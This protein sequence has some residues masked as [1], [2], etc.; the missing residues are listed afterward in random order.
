MRGAGDAVLFTRNFEPA[1]SATKIEPGGEDS[2][3]PPFFAELVPVQAGAQS[4]VI[5]GP[6]DAQLGE[7]VLAGAAPSVDHRAT[8]EFL[9]NADAELVYNGRRLAEPH[10]LG[11]V[12]GGRRSDV[13][14][15][16]HVPC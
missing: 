16:G 4:I 2:E 3:G 9:R 5:I 1:A 11:G 8:R 13:G 6:G 14:H 12:L 7:I 10:V 15:A